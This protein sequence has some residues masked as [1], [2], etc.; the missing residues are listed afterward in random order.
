MTN[1]S[2]DA[3]NWISVGALAQSFAPD[4]NNLVRSADLDGKTLTLHFADGRT[5]TCAFGKDG[6]ISFSGPAG[7]GDSHCLATCLRPGIYFVDF[8]LPD[9]RPPASVSLVLDLDRKV[10]TSVV[11]QLP[12]GE[13]AHRSIF[14][15]A[16]QQQELTSVGADIQ[17]A[18]IDRPFDAA[19]AH[20][21]ATTELTGVRLQHRYNP[22]E[23]YEHIYLNEHRYAWHCL[24]GAEKGLADVDRAH[25]IKIADKLYLFIWREKV[26]PTLGAVLV[27]LE[28]MKTTG[29]IFGYADDSLSTVSNFQVGAVSKL[30]N[31]TVHTL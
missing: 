23:V 24:S 19:A 2:A 31:T 6:A 7:R 9:A 22:H 11:A 18:S 28:Q 17:F 5:A 25:Y 12:A 29:K 10:A 16:Q 26:V 20:H 4:N 3:T 15:Q 30:V 1:A 21:A 14:R 8:V 27:D 13:V